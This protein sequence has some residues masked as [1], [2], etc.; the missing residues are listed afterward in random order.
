MPQGVWVSRFKN[1]TDAAFGESPRE[2]LL[3]RG[4]T[5][6]P[7]NRRSRGATPSRAA[8][9]RMTLEEHL[10]EK[11]GISRDTVRTFLSD[12]GGGYGLGPDALSGYTGYAF[13]EL[14]PIPERTERKCS[15]TATA[16]SQA[17][18][19]D[20]DSGIHCRLTF[21]RRCVSE[22][23]ELCRSRSRWRRCAHSSG[24]DRGMG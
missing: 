14:G 6:P 21:A 18:R 5:S 4:A 24:F 11:Y 9:T 10:M 20:F 1:W 13:D 17:H 15:P 3:T 2:L 16:A 12:E 19:E 22:E 23:R 7:E 8:S